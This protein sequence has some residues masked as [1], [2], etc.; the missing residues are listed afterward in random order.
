MRLVLIIW[1]LAIAAAQHNG[2]PAAATV[3]GQAITLTQLDAEIKPQ[4]ALATM[5][6]LLVGSMFSSATPS[7]PVW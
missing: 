4:L 5:V 6:A 7:P 3:N 1:P 2:Q